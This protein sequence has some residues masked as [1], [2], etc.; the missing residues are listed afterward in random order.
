MRIQPRPTFR[1]TAGIMFPTWE[2][3]TEAVRQIVQAK[4]WPANCRILDPAEAGRAAGLDGTQ[5]LVIVSFESA[6]LLAAPRH[7]PGRRHRPRRR[8]A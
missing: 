4:L 8:R 5:S 7:R 3:G 1:A 2:A 6:D